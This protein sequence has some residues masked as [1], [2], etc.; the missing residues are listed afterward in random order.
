M[1]DFWGAIKMLIG[2]KIIDWLFG[3]FK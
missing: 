2:L 3:L 1:K